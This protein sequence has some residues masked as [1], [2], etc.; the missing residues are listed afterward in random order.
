VK[1]GNFKILSI[2][3]KP[4]EDGKVILKIKFNRAGRKMVNRLAKQ[5]GK[6]PE[7]LIIQ[8]MEMFLEEKNA[9]ERPK[10]DFKIGENSEFQCERRKDLEDD[11]SD[12]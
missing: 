12:K 7:E 9:L 5:T 8:G 11:I 2:K 6:T 10:P 3:E 4:G 1:E